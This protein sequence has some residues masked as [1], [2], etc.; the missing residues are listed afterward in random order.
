M[1]VGAWCQSTCVDSSQTTLC[2]N[3]I[4]AS[5]DPVTSGVKLLFEGPSFFWYSQH[6]IQ[7]ML[8]ELRRKGNDGRF[9]SKCL[10]KRPKISEQIVS[11]FLCLQGQIDFHSIAPLWSDRWMWA[12]DVGTIIVYDYLCVWDFIELRRRGTITVLCMLSVCADFQLPDTRCRDVTLNDR[13]LRNKQQNKLPFDDV[14]TRSLHQ[15]THLQVS[16][17]VSVLREETIRVT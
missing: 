7:S 15:Y 3:K 1:C 10:F 12:E 6:H 13:H 14:D 9:F 5:K 2:F 16:E 8:N 11:F 17:H 4:T